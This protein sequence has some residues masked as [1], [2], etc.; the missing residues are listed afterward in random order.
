[1]Y[2]WPIFTKPPWCFTGV[3]HASYFSVANHWFTSDSSDNTQESEA[4]KGKAQH[5]QNCWVDVRLIRGKK[6][7]NKCEGLQRES[8][9]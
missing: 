4:K 8:D 3:E 9:N 7:L 1:M 5:C 2:F 6:V